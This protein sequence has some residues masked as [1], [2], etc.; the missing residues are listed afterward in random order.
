[1]D[2]GGWS[3]EQLGNRQYHPCSPAKYFEPARK[4]AEQMAKRFGHNRM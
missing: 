3:R 2:G 4:I 1:V